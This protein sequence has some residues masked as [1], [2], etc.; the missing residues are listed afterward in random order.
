MFYYI[1]ALF[2]IALD[3][4]T[5]YLIVKNMELGESIKVI[6]D[7]LYI[8]SHRNRGAAWG[9]LE[10]QMW[11]FYIITVIVII[12][13][14]YYIQKA[15]KGKMLFGVSLGFMLGGAIGNFIDRVFRNEVVDFVNTYIFGYDF[16][17]F[18]IA[19]SALVI[20][21]AMLMIQM[22]LEERALKKEKTHGENG[23]HHS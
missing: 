20:G 5:K 3:Q 11:F 10:G 19:D 8:T 21:V 6:E 14:V 7:F 2:I 9:I 13:I 17:V 22:L 16:P 12:G 4:L 23:T 18:N 15:A 1:I